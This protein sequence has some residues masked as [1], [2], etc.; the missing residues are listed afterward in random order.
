[1][2]ALPTAFAPAERASEEI[3]Q[4]QSQFFLSLSPFF[5]IIDTVPDIVIVLNKERQIVFCNW[6]L[7]LF[8]GKET[9]EIL[10]GKRPGEVLGC[11][12]AF[13]SDGGC[14]TTEFCSTCGAAKAILASQRGHSQVQECRIIRKDTGDSLDLRVWTSHLRIEDQ[15]FTIFC[16]VDISNEKRREA[17][18]R[19]FF[20]DVLNVAGGIQGLTSMFSEVGPAQ[21]EEFMQDIYRL[22]RT[23]VEEIRAQRDL[24][25]AENDELPVNP[26][27][28]NTLDIL[29]E[30]QKA[31]RHHE[32]SRDREILIDPATAN[33]EFVSDRSILLRVIGNMLKNALEA[34]KRKQSVT[35]GCSVVD[36]TIQFHVHNPEAIPREVQLQIFQRSYSTKGVGRGLGTYSV[37]LLS[38]RYLKGR[39]DFSS[40]LSDGTVFRAKYPMSL[41]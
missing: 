17:L 14:G 31:Y 5:K 18:E 23:L 28:L 10:Y 39:V 19:I 37:K 11:E 2:A 20:H 40:S 29:K 16:I 9:K 38:E 4:S 22:S 36:G 26:A 6:S 12:H 25:A 8:V 15:E 1:M 35:I 7:P 33:V 41:V 30:V 24:I 21:R 13:E 27:S 3:V 32:V 34:T